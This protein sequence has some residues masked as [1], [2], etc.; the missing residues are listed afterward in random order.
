[1][2]LDCFLYAWYP[3]RSNPKISL[4]KIRWKSIS[5][6][7][8][9]IL[10]ILFKLTKSYLGCTMAESG[11]NFV[12]RNWTL[13]ALW[14]DKKWQCSSLLACDSAISK[15][16]WH[17]QILPIQRSFA[18]SFWRSTYSMTIFIRLSKYLAAIFRFLGKIRWTERIWRVD[19]DWS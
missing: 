11:F 9:K 2:L 5:F 15:N 4:E 19:I 3:L 1:M 7:S 18:R 14:L 16:A 12:F 6:T 10:H 17:V 8:Q 13:I